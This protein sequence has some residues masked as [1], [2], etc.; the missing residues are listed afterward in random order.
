MSTL[1]EMERARYREEPGNKPGRVKKVLEAFFVPG[2]NAKTYAGGEGK[3]RCPGGSGMGPIPRNGRWYDVTDYLRK[4]V[5]SGDAAEGS[6]TQ[7]AAY[8]KVAVAAEAKVKSRAKKAA[9]ENKA[10]DAAKA[11]E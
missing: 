6:D 3:F 4:C 2:P 8:D 11:K 9:A 5:R 10:A 7:I 1:P